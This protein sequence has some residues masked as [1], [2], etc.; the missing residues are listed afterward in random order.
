MTQTL[1]TA[2]LVLRPLTVADG[3]FLI[4][5]LNDPDFLRY[6]GDRGVRDAGSA[7]RYLREGPWASYAAHGHGLLAVEVPQAGPVGMAGLLRREHLDG[8]DLGYALLPQH[9]GR[10]YAREAAIALMRHAA[11]DLNLAELLA[12]VRPGNHRSVRLLGEL[13]FR[14]DPERTGRYG[15]AEGVD[16]YR[17]EAATVPP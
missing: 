17:W 6:I 3:P 15:A 11:R 13:G 5:L 1:T 4:E 14:H 9:R 7:E 8:V 16:V 2:R 12:I 10:G